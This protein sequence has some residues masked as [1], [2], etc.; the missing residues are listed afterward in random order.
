MTD[1]AGAGA[2]EYAGRSFVGTP[3]TAP[4]P[5]GPQMLRDFWAIRS[6]PLEYLH[7]MWREYGDVVQF[8]IPRPPSY[9]VNDPEG[10]RRVLVANARNY[11]KSTIQYRSLSLVTGEGLLVADTE[12][13]RRQRPLVQPAFH[14]QTLERIVTHVDVAMGRLLDR[15]DA[16]EAGAVV[17]VDEAMMHAALEVVG[18]ALFGTDLSADAER[19]ASATVR[20]LDVVIARARVPITPP[21]WLPTPGNVR[22]RRSVAELD[23][24]V[25]RMMDERRLAP[26][27][28]PCDMLDLLIGST[29][30]TG[31]GLGAEEIRD[32]V[33]TFIVAGHE[34]VAS[35]LT[36][37]WALLAAHPDAQRRLQCESDEV[38]GGR[39]A[40]FADYPRLPFARAVLDEALRMYPPAWLLTRKAEA[41]DELGSHAI[42]ASALIILSPWLLHRHPEMWPRPEEFRPERFIDGEADRSAFIPFGAG[43]RQC[44]GRDF[45]YLEGVLMLSAIAGRFTL[46][47]PAGAGVPAAAPLVTIRPVG[48]LPLR[49]TRR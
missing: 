9:L 45:A 4:G 27:A 1:D 38:L 30:D 35:A 34:T 36:W 11:G 21:A 2:P 5:L 47:Y 7:R 20:A 15:W 31:T 37:A 46:A 44:I 24:A 13:W 8:P 49:V 42:P 3:A 17:D 33:V 26:S 39:A 41:A 40:R 6:N 23:V 22:L 18:H 28:D 12:P 14:H 16:L 43:P 25:R 19:L 29:D 10:V 32:Q 48:G